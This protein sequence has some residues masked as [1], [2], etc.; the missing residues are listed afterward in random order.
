MS[1]G[2]AQH[3]EKSRCPPR[4][5]CLQFQSQKAL[6]HCHSAHSGGT[7]R[8]LPPAFLLPQP[9][10]TV[11]T[12]KLAGRTAGRVFEGQIKDDLTL[13]W[14]KHCRGWA[15]GSVLPVLR[16]SP[17]TGVSRELKMGDAATFPANLIRVLSAS[18]LT[19]VNLSLWACKPQPLGVA[20]VG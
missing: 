20:D 13:C 10:A 16:W 17:R 3:F 19:S 9:H 14:T 18:T 4:C 8:M 2:A 7:F 12:T 11:S 6:S 5:S 1:G 15:G